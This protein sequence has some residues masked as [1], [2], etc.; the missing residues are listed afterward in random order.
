M[1]TYCVDCSALGL[2]CFD[3]PFGHE[4][5]CEGEIYGQTHWELAGLMATKHGYN[6]GWQDLERIYFVS[7]P[8]ADT[9]VPFQS[10][11]VYDAY[12]MVDDDNGNLADGTPNCA[13]ILSTFSLHG[14]AS[15]P[16]V[17][18]TAGCTR[19]AEPVITPTAAADRIILDWTVSAGATTYRV[20]RSDFG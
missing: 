16:C 1:G 14:I 18:T 9:M 3:G 15:V 13:E 4:V 17:A 20:L 7:L 5:H 6:T 19:P 2:N 10:G 12:L 8:Q 11:N